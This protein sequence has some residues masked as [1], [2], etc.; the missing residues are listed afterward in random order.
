M[1]VDQDAALDERTNVVKKITRLF[2]ENPSWQIQTRKI[3]YGWA[4]VTT[5]CIGT[6]LNG[7]QSSRL[8]SYNT[9]NFFT[10]VP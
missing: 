8:C 4:L 6:E 10:L 3:I 1:V 7:P 5:E 9:R 2:W